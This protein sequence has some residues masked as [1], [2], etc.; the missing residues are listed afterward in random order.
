MRRL[1]RCS[2]PWR[3]PCWRPRRRLGAANREHEQMMADIRML[4]E[5][6]QRLQLALVTLDEALKTRQRED[7]RSV[8]P[9]ARASPIRSCSSTA[10]SGDL[11][12]LREKLDETNVRLTSLSQDV[13]GLRDIVASG[14]AGAACSMPGRPMRTGQPPTPRAPHPARPCPRPPA[15]GGTGTTP[16]RLYDTAYADYT[17]GQWSLAVQ[18]F[19]T[20]LKTFPKSDLADDAQYYI[21]EALQRRHEVHGGRRRLRARDQRL[22]AK[23]H[24]A[25]GVLQGRQH[26]RAARAA[27]QGARRV[28]VRR[29]ALSARPRRARS[30]SSGSTASTGEP[31]SRRRSRPRWTRRRKDRTNMGS[32]NKVILVGNLGRDAEL[33]YTPGGAA[34]ATLNLATTE[35]WNDKEGQRQE[36]T[37]WHRVI[38]WGKQAE[39]LN[40]YLQK[41][42]Q[43]YVEG[44][45]QTRQWDDKDGNKRYTT[46]IRGDRVVLLS[47]GGGGGGGQRCQRRIAAAAHPEPTDVG[48]E[49]SEDDIPF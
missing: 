14:D 48:P 20:Y 33:R 19:E 34:V 15:A 49:L 7:R 36:K 18:G 24:P 16:A 21:G 42:K 27:R 41:G 44:R 25:R 11:R 35:T 45:L 4:Q 47:S 31:A 10:S 38:L 5:Q 6:N 30:P 29:Q 32:V 8:R 1:Q 17:A 12:V 26:L 2:S 23:R 3:S 28:R 46:E 37:E 40:Q 43:I 13:D 39:T 9:R 22:P